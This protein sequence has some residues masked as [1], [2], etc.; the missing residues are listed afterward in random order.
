MKKIIII[1]ALLIVT[2]MSSFGQTKYPLS[3]ISSGTASK[4]C[5]RSIEN[6]DI[7]LCNIKTDTINFD[8]LNGCKALTVNENGKQLITSFKLGYFLPNTTTFVE[9][10]VAGNQI[11]KDFV[12]A[13]IK[14][15][16]KKI[17]FSEILGIDGTVNLDLGYRWFYFKK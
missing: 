2:T 1:L 8:Q 3:D 5:H 9:R 14:S 17:I 13:I 10:Y 11:P 12:D 6:K 4:S 15:G 16:A 7:G